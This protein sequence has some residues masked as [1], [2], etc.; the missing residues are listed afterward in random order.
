MVDSG[1]Q[2]KYESPKYE[3]LQSCGQ[4]CEE[5]LYESSIWVVTNNP[6][7][8]FFESNSLFMALFKYIQGNNDKKKTI[9]MTVPVL[10]KYV[11]DQMMD[12]RFFLTND[13]SQEIYSPTDKD[14]VYIQNQPKQTFFVTSFGG[15]S[16]STI[17]RDK[18]QELVNILKE[19]GLSGS[20]DENTFYTAGYDSPW[21]PFN[22]HNEIWIEKISRE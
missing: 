11:G 12:M 7:N 22:R 18:H 17:I 5:R 15:Y 21:K 6:K 20:F 3:T 1:S 4:K 10:S 16:S 19:K 14:R 2:G 8:S 9:N 13:M